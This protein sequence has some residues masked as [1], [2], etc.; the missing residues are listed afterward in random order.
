MISVGQARLV[1]LDFIRQKLNI[2]KFQK[3][4]DIKGMLKTLLCT[5]Y[6]FTDFKLL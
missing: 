2:P 3:P 4:V 5:T 1:R 6:D